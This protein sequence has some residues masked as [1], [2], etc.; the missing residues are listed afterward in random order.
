MV[1]PTP[2]WSRRSHTPSPV[3][4]TTTDL[5]HW[6]AWR[7]E[8][9]DVVIG[10][11]P[12]SDIVIDA[13]S[14]SRYHARIAWTDG[15]AEVEDLLS[16]N[17][18]FY[19]GQPART[20]HLEDGD[21]FRLGSVLCMYTTDPTRAVLPDGRRVTYLTQHSLFNRRKNVTPD[22]PTVAFSP[23][24]TTINRAQIDRLILSQNTCTRGTLIAEKTGQRW[25]LG[26]KSHRFGWR[27][28]IQVDGWAF[29]GWTGHG[30]G[31][32]VEWNGS[33][34][35]IC[36]TAIFASITVNGHEVRRRRLRHGDRI[37]VSGRAFRYLAR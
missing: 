2:L 6:N 32:I 15:R 7:L 18:S 27:T 19:K 4:C 36:T 31:A 3:L 22:S 16:S 25:R 21:T 30:H 26:A 9:E 13:R 29:G 35:R 20:F 14:V 33:S 17:G 12:E 8:C 1:A 5:R 37:T 24:T 11:D 23:G 34:H 10:R 28:E